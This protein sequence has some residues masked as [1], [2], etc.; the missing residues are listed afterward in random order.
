M[1]LFI[2]ATG[3]ILM[4]A[5]VWLTSAI[6]VTDVSDNEI[7]IEDIE[8]EDTDLFSS[9]LTLEEFERSVYN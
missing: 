9:I 2:K 8:N 1:K 6:E 4:L 5:C 7:E 3:F